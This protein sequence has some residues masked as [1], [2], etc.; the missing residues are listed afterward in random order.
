MS[1]QPATSASPSPSAQEPLGYMPG[2][3]LVRLR[4]GGSFSAAGVAGRLPGV[5]LR[6][7]TQLRGGSGSGGGF[8]AA[9]AAHNQ[10]LHL[11]ISD[12]SS[13]EDKVQQLSA[14]AAVQYAE[15]NWLRGFAAPPPADGWGGS[16][17]SDA[18]SGTRHRQRRLQQLPTDP[19]LADPTDRL[20]AWHLPR[21]SAPSAWDSTVGSRQVRVQGVRV[22]A[23][24]GRSSRGTGS[25]S[26][27]RGGATP[28]ER[29]ASQVRTFGGGGGGE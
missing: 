8:A 26:V 3:V 10:L 16:A 5:R 20:Y 14:L 7:A 27:N 6:R 17:S 22:C 18:G 9:A 1:S 21:V 19:L 4:R 29:W 23:G 13:V 12:G 24:R 11:V 28:H 15:P 2:E 25:S